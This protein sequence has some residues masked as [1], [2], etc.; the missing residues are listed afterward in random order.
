MKQTE[1]D[2]ALK[3]QRRAKASHEAEISW[4]QSLTPDPPEESW[5]VLGDW[6]K[7]DNLETYIK[8]PGGYLMLSGMMVRVI[9][10]EVIEVQERDRLTIVN[11]LASQLRLKEQHGL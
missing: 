7:R 1:I 5:P 8:L 6:G 2:Q 11:N 4:L 9:A 3:E 10:I